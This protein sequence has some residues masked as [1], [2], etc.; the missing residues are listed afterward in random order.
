M[1]VATR[2]V[3][4]AVVYLQVVDT[5]QGG[6]QTSTHAHAHHTHSERVVGVGWRV[7]ERERGGERT[8]RA[9]LEPPPHLDHR[10]HSLPRRRPPPRRPQPHA[11]RRQHC[12]PRSAAPAPSTAAPHAADR[13][14]ASLLPAAAAGLAHSAAAASLARLAAA[15][16]TPRAASP[17]ASFGFLRSHPGPPAPRPEGCRLVGGRRRFVG[18]GSGCTLRARCRVGGCET[19]GRGARLGQ[20]RS[21]Q[22]CEGECA[23]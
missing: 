3:P 5:W 18:G 19:G 2:R 23:R 4:S 17:C 11:G 12:R 1:T 9:I 13:A 22:V 21:G 14:A 15:A 20:V 16:A 6:Q 7:D 8:T 10:H